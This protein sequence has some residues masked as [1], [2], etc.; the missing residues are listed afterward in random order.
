MRK[1]E[2]I[3]GAFGLAGSLASS[4]CAMATIQHTA[5]EK[6]WRDAATV[7][8][9][10]DVATTIYGL[11]LPNVREGN[12]LVGRDAERMGLLKMS[13]LILVYGFGESYPEWRKGIYQTS[14]IIGTA[15]TLLNLAQ[16]VLYHIKK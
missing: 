6:M 8:H 15:A 13:H 5:D 1:L 12:P 16:I 7:A 14:A 3:L 9:S 11:T 10:T 4:G 2:R